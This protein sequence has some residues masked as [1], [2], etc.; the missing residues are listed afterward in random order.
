M[1]SIYG[2]ANAPIDIARKKVAR[3]NDLID[4]GLTTCDLGRFVIDGDR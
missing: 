2:R 4:T 1:P 3:L